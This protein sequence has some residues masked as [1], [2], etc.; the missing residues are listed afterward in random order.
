M[1]GVADAGAGPASAADL[2]AVAR[3][4]GRP[5]AGAFTVVVRGRDGAP[6]VIR[7][8]PL[9]HDGTP[10]PTRYWLVGRRE[11]EAVGRLESTGG[12]RAAESAVPA[13]E[14]AAAHARY[15]AERDAALPAGYAG[16]RPAGGVGGTRRG[17][18]CLHA[19]LAW[20]LAGG[21]D[22]VGRWVAARLAGELE[23]PVAAIDCGTNSTRLLVADGEGRSL[24]RRMTITRLGE[25]VDRTGELGA[26][27]LER[28]LAV[29]GEYRRVADGFSVVRLRA[30]A[31]SAARDARNAAA[32]FDAAEA[33]L[34]VRLELLEGAEEGRIAYAGATAELDPADGPYLVVDLGG[35]STELVAGAP[36]AGAAPAAVVS[37]ETGCVR[38]TERFLAS[39]PPT[40]GELAAA[41]AEVR[42]L[43]GAA[44]AAHPALALPRRMV[45]VAGTVSTL[46]ALHLGLDGFERERLHHARLRRDVVEALL[47]SLAAEPVALRRERVG[48]DR[49]R[50]DVIVGGAVVLAEA[51][52]GLG[53]DELVA[54]ESD[55]LDGL[56]ADL[57]RAGP[58]PRDAGR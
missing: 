40:A 20:Y 35:G 27:A 53:H 48:L 45:G 25:G 3:L 36:G 13:G 47:A 34:G 33:V 22:P 30:I 37:L 11:R 41:R 7:N 8:D 55:I 52:A 42:A 12:V 49:A 51:M 18:K 44:V 1:A 38:V 39:D 10:M 17:V 6:V 58:G 54:S 29:L 24:E 23:G 2:E 32:L 5:P 56:V 43:V 50:A 26:G 31:T 9:L 14:L 4:L 46:V 21:G 19:H 28:T 15:A 57:L 16:L